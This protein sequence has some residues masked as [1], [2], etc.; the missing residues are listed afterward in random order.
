MDKAV[1]FVDSILAKVLVV[2]IAA[3]VI[4]VSWQVFTRFIM[5]DP[6]SFT[7]EVANFLLIWASLLGSAYAL[8]LKSH[9]GIDILTA[10][11]DEQNQ[12]KWE[13]VIYFFVILFSALVLIWGGFRLVNI[14]LHLNQVSA[15][16]RLKV[17]YVYMI[18]PL[19]GGLLIFYSLYFINEARKKLKVQS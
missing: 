12:T 16:L 17:G 9:L 10:K 2:L 18:L 7:E 6:S 1:K 5:D 13:F 14:T 3:I 15:A 11:M 4:D 19:T 8:R